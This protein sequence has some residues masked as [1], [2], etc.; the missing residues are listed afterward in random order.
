MQITPISPERLVEEVAELVA[1]RAASRVP[2]SCVPGSAAPI[3]TRSLTAA[4]RL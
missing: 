4:D 1:P 3:P 2:R